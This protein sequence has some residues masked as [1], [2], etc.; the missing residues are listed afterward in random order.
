MIEVLLGRCFE[1]GDARKDATANAILCDAAKEALDLVEP[2]C[3]GRGEVHMEARMPF[4]PRLDH[5]VLVRG[6]VV[7]DQMQAQRLGRIAVDGAEEFAP[8]L[9]TV[10]LHA[11]PDH[12]CGG[13][14]EGGEQRRRV[15]CSSL[16]LIGQLASGDW[17]APPVG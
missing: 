8:F 2:G 3:G 15:M 1:L 12:L 17:S 14:V 5:V 16:D 10:S 11:L 13:D 9:V 6:V 7:G 4:E